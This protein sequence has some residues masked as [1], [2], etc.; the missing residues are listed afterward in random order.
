[1]TYFPLDIE[2]EVDT[3]L[4]CGTLKLSEKSNMSISTLQARNYKK[5]Y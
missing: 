5:Q 4:Y 3:L 1:M 2:S